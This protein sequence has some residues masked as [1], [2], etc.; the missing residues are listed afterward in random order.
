MATVM[1]AASAVGSAV[2]A[3]AV[4]LSGAEIRDLLTGNTAVGRWEGASYRQFFG[5][6]GVTIFAQDGARSARGNWRVDDTSLEYQSIWPG[7]DTWEGWFVMAYGGTYYWVSRATPPT[8]F[9]V[10]EGQQLLAE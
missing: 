3:Q 6:D 7:D 9:Q 10:L 2:A 1:V 8:P 4:K 5:A